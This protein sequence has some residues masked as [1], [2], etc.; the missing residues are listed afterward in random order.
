MNLELEPHYLYNRLE[1]VRLNKSRVY[2]NKMYRGPS[3]LA[4]N[5]V[6]YHRVLVSPLDKHFGM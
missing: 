4:V 3:L 2:N 6:E 5:A 1:S